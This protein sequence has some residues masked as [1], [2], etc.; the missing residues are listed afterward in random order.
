MLKPL[1]AA[2]VAASVVFS[3]RLLLVAQRPPG[4]VSP[5]GRQAASPRVDGDPLGRNAVAT[6]AGER[7]FTET[8]CVGCHSNRAKQ[9]ACPWKGCR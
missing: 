9:A 6:Q 4:V 3:A 7:T 8:Y 1:S 2:V 5:V